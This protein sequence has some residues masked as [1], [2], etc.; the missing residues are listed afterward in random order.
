MYDDVN[1]IRMPNYLVRSKID[2]ESYADS[3]GPMKAGQPDGNDLTSNIR[4][5]T[6]ESWINNSNNFRNDIMVSAM[7]KRNA[8]M[9]QNRMYPKST[10]GQRMAGRR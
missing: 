8:E 2:F 5:L 7:R 1:A 10:S 9:W 6:Q 3:Y 4:E